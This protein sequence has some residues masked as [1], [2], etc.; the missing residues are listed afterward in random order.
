MTLNCTTVYIDDQA[1][2]LWGK[3]NIKHKQYMFCIANLPSRDMKNKDLHLFLEFG[4]L[5]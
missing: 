4:A 3:T 1:V 5:K 2:N